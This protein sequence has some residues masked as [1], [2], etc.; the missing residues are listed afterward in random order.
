MKTIINKI[1]IYIFVLISASLFACNDV[2]DQEPISTIS[3]EAYF[4]SESQLKDY[5]D[6]LYIP[7]GVSAFSTH[8]SSY[9]DFGT[10]GIDNNTDNMNGKSY[11]TSFLPGELKVGQTGGDWYFGYIYKH[12]YFFKNAGQKLEEGKISGNKE[13]IN[14]Y[15]G[16]VYVLRAWEYFKRLQSVGDFPIVTEPLENNME[17]LIEASKR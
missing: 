10:F 13:N 14:H 11:S 6:E 17:L 9:M 7:G 4:S 2:L 12:N 1:K 8:S 3:P 5:V 15:F 16:E